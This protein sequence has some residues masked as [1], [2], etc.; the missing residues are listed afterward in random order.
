MIDL[1]AQ[2]DSKYEVIRLEE[3]YGPNYILRNPEYYK[4]LPD[5]FSLSDPDVEFP[6]NI[7]GNFQEDAQG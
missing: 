2:I 7:S 4:T 1:L 6:K 5:I 3:N